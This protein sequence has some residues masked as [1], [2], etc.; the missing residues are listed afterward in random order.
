MASIIWKRHRDKTYTSTNELGPTLWRGER[1][2]R[3][4]RSDSLA[5]TKELQSSIHLGISQCPVAGNSQ[6]DSQKDF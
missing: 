6:A 3:E 5:P 4:E 2:Q 1:E